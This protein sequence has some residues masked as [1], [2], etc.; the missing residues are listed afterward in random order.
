MGDITLYMAPGSCARVTCIALEEL[1]L[2]FTTQVVR[3]MRGEHRA[4]EYLAL[5][6]KGKVPT[7]LHHGDVITENVAI[8]R[9]LHECYGGLFPT[10]ENAV[11]RAAILADL[12]FCSATLHPLV[13]RIR[14]PMMFADEQ[15][16]VNVKSV[17]A[18]AMDFQFELIEQRLADQPWWYGEQWSA[19]DAYI[20]WVFFR[21]EGAGYD[22]S[23]FPAYA[24]HAERI[25]E[26]E[27]VVR[28]LQREA[29]AQ[30]Q[31]EREGCAFVPPNIPIEAVAK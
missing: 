7:L 17:A 11:Q 1:G 21:V 31:L 29:D 30:A 24:A 8:L 5:N 25:S 26:R 12:C 13:T 10:A 15:H 19:L 16:A 18:A 20:F 4:A 27:S 23:R 14:M 6:P 28:A 2:D 9:F 22:V 3:F